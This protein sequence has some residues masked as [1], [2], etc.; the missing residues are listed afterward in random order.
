M[1]RPYISYQMSSFRAKR[2]VARNLFAID[3][4]LNEGRANPVGMRCRGVLH[5]PPIAICHNRLQGA[6]AIRPY[7]HHQ[8]LKG[9]NL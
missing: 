4:S 1:P 8:A 7:N 6:Y 3:R 2:S 9:R 5:T